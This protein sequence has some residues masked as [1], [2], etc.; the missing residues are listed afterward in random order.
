MKQITSYEGLDGSLYRSKGECL[1]ADAT[2]AFKELVGNCTASDSGEF[3]IEDF[4]DAI[5]KDE[6]LK[7][8]I[9]P[10]FVVAKP[11]RTPKDDVQKEDEAT[12]DSVDESKDADFTPPN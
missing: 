11:K 8:L 3:L 2:F 6:E 12:P 7:A 10:L 1:V 9:S 5:N 4:L